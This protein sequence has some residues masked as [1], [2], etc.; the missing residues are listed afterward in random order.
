MTPF[1]QP[2]ATVSTT[3]P[4]VQ[5]KR[6]TAHTPSA[7]DAR[8]GA[9]NDHE[10]KTKK[11]DTRDPS[12]FDEMMASLLTL[13]APAK[14]QAQPAEIAG[15]TSSDTSP[16][17]AGFTMDPA[18]LVADASALSSAQMQPSAQGDSFSAEL[19]AAMTPGLP[20]TPVATQTL[21]A[22]PITTT[23]PAS[24]DNVPVI[25]V[26]VPVIP[27]SDTSSVLKVAVDTSDTDPRMI[28][29]GFNPADMETLKEKFALHTSKPADPANVSLASNGKDSTTPPSAQ[30]TPQSQIP[31]NNAQL[32]SPA[33]KSGADTAA[34]NSSGIITVSFVKDAPVQISPNLSSVVAQ[35]QTVNTA[36][37]TNSE[38]QAILSAGVSA[39]MVTDQLIE[40]GVSSLSGQDTAPSDTSSFDPVE[41][42]IAQRFQNGPVAPHAARTEA[43]NSVSFSG[44]NTSVSPNSQ[45]VVNTPP[46]N[47]GVA[48]NAHAAI[49]TKAALPS[50]ADQSLASASG[51]YPAGTDISALVST[52][53]G[54]PQNVA[55][56][57][58]SPVSQNVAAGQS[59]PAVQATAAAIIKG[60]KTEGSQTLSLRLDPPDL[61]KLQ[62]DMKYKK[63][64]P[65]KVHVVLEK[66]DT[67][68]MF[69]RDAHALETALK[70]AGLDTDGSSLS[71]SLAGD[72]R[73]FGQSMA[74]SGGGDGRNATV[75][76]AATGDVSAD[77]DIIASDL[78]IYTDTSGITRY[79]LRV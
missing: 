72:Q 36:S 78:D 33:I 1:A 46:A 6:S 8:R 41:F 20:A 25:T 19:V 9:D 3:Q 51:I 64:D 37:A 40:Q 79:N 16:V 15:S 53:A 38:Q 74:Q 39:D 21:P 73:S 12:V 47:N 49:N 5:A 35:P 50:S 77:A 55:S 28:A 54:I 13:A 32:P 30:V 45:T 29:C 31:A 2:V 14:P 75:K 57:I 48:P 26:P 60:A 43:A 62:I 22:S 10:I 52:P 11:P 34:Q 68:S 65:L 61:G 59:H 23:P 7:A 17:T 56:P 66:A 24:T 18:M 4:P 70:N 63:G 76:L 27:V 67:A 42:R 44:G 71:F 69:Q 58:S